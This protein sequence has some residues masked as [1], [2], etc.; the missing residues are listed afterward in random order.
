MS[1][2]RS[3]ADG[4]NWA[5]PLVVTVT[6]T[7]VAA[8]LASETFA[9]T[10]QAAPTGVPLQLSPTVPVNPAPGVSWS[11]YCAVC[12]AETEAPVELPEATL[13]V[14]AGL[15]VASSEMVLRGSRNVI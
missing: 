7:F 6:V 9:G 5:E 15:A 8:P 1:G 11:W 3:G 14:N 10:W 2:R 13:T 4:G 12:P